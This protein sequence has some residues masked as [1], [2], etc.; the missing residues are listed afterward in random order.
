M[1]FIECL[2]SCR[3]PHGDHLWR[4]FSTTAAGTATGTGTG[5]ATVTAAASGG[6]NA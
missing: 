6:T 1:C 4:G 3:P 5:T 2:H